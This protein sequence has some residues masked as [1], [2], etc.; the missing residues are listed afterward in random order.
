MPM[1]ATPAIKKTLES[2]GVTINAHT[3]ILLHRT[4]STAAGGILKTGFRTR[5]EKYGQ[6][7]AVATIHFDVNHASFKEGLDSKHQSSTHNMVMMVPEGI[8]EQL[9]AQLA[10]HDVKVKPQRRLEAIAE[11]LGG[12]LPR[13]W[14]VGTYAQDKGK[15]TPNKNFDPTHQPTFTHLSQLVTNLE[16]NKK[17]QESLGP[18]RTPE[19]QK[20]PKPKKGKKE[21]FFF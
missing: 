9:N 8:H 20:T 16:A 21:T 17:W 14:V 4:I 13:E 5:L 2:K 18:V 19:I 12:T 10:P 3:P 6:M 15:F 11:A 1:E 7:A